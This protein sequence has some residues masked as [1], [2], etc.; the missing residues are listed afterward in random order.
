MSKMAELAYD[1]EQLYIEGY[2]AAQIAIKLNCPIAQVQ[3]WLDY[4]GVADMQQE[5][6]ASPFGTINS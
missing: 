1:I 5:E 4:E 2:S 6:D 3:G